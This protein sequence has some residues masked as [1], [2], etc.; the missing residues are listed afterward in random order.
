MIVSLLAA[1]IVL[2]HSFPAYAGENTVLRIEAENNK[3]KI[4]ASCIM[5]GLNNVT[6]GKIRIKYNPAELTLTKTTVGNALTNIMTEINDS[7]TGNKEPGEIVIAFASAEAVEQKGS[8]IEMEFQQGSQFQSEK[9]IELELSVE[10]FSMDGTEISVSSENGIIPGSSSE[11]PT[12]ETNPPDEGNNEE[13]PG[14]ESGS[15]NTERGSKEEKSA[16]EKKAGKTVKTG[17]N[18]VVG[19]VISLAICSI[20]VGGLIIARKKI[21]K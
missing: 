17:D 2:V 12:D 9:D 14:T 15:T 3:G 13:K 19:E 10:E 4:N 8:I 18:T 1:F 7:I 11:K 6:N 5:D 21:C 20:I 16:A